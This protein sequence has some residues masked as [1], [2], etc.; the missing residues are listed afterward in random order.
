[1]FGPDQQSDLRRRLKLSFDHF[2]DAQ[3]QSDQEIAEFIREREID[4]AVDLMGFTQGARTNVFARRPAPV[5]VTYLGYPSTTAAEYMDYIVADRTV[6]PEAQ[7][8]YYTEKVVWLPDCYQVNDAQ[9]P[10]A[11]TPTRSECALPEDAFVYCCF[12]NTYKITPDVFDIWMRLLKATDNSV[13][14]LMGGNPLAET[15]LAQEANN[16]GVASERLIFAAKV[17]LMT[18]HLARQQQA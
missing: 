15:N 11:A 5:Q 8:R 12:N 3:V 7:H 17:P 1:S 6:I 14:W 16:R 18:D 2:I 9:R 4:I 13:L 10:I